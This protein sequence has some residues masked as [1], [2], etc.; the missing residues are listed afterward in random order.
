MFDL[1][2]RLRQV[3]LWRVLYWLAR[4]GLSL[5][6]IVSGIR[7]LPGVLFTILPTTDPVGYYFDAMHQ[8]GFYWNFIGVFQILLGLLIFF[9]RFVVIS[10]LLMMPVT[11]NIF[12][13]SFAL[14]MK[15]T[16]FITTLMLLANLFLL[17]WNYEN[18]LSLL[19][20]GHSN[21]RHR[22]L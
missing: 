15:G 9:N 5:A 8:T 20:K 12:L 11:V 19:K 10:V 18:Y 22:S 14:N 4:I 7:K 21:S 6:F 2:N 13:V 17:L 3:P 16:P 1:I